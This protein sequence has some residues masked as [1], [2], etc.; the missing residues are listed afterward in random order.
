M[1]NADHTIHNLHDILKFYYKV[2]RKRLVDVLCMQQGAD[3]HLATGPETP[4]KVFSLNLVT[5]LK[6]EQMEGSEF[7]GKF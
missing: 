4:T 2:A 3:F 6:P 7:A 1:S 5:N